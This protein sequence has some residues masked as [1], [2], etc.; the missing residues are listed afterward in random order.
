MARVGP[1]RQ[2]NGKMLTPQPVMSPEPHVRLQAIHSSS[3][4]SAL[5]GGEWL[6]VCPGERDHGTHWIKC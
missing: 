4:A 3:L 2:K 6:I 1:Q 5:D